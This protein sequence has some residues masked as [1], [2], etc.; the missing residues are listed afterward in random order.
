MTSSASSGTGGGSGAE[1]VVQQIAILSALVAI[2]ACWPLVAK[3]IPADDRFAFV[4]L[5]RE[6]WAHRHAMEPW[7][8]QRWAWLAAHNYHLWFALGALPGVIAASIVQGVD[9]KTAWPML[10]AP[11]G[12]LAGAVLGYML[13]GLVPV[14]RRSPE[15]LKFVPGDRRD[16]QA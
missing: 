2:W 4:V 11:L 5:V 15:S 7:L 13:Y 16:D 6:H 8:D 14:L 9:R 1:P 10:H 12:W 3:L